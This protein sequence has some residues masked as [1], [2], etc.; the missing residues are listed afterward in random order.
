MEGLGDGQHR[1]LTSQRHDVRRDI[2]EDAGG[3]QHGA[4]Q[5][6][7]HPDDEVFRRGCERGQ[8]VAERGEVAKDH[9]HRDLQKIFD[10]KFFPQDEN[11]KQDQNNMK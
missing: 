3:H 11:L 1:P 5:D 8:K 10:F 2:K 9:A 6:H 7:Q 4:D